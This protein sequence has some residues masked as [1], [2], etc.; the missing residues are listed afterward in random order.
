MRRCSFIFSY[1]TR[2]AASPEASITLRPIFSF[3]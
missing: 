2:Y 1:R 3:L